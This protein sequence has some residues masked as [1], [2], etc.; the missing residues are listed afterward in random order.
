MYARLSALVL[1]LALVFTA[2]A[3]AQ[4]RFGSLQGRVTDQQA[5]PIPGV[6]VTVTSLSSGE[7][8]NFVTDV[9]GQ[10]V[11][12]DLNPGRYKV[13]F[14]LRRLHRKSSVRTSASPS[15]APSRSTRR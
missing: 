2:H 6:T 12:S 15:G 11:A 14:E 7:S 13:L 10:F 5:A 1:V 3:T 8:R 9:N 4:E